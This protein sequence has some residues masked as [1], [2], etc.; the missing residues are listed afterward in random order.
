[1]DE[2]ADFRGDFLEA[3]E[4]EDRAACVEMALHRLEMGHTDVL[5]LYREVLAPALNEWQR[6]EA[7]ADICVW[8]EHVRTSIVRTVV[9][10]A[11]PY[12]VKEAAR[13]DLAKGKGARVAVLCP[14][15]ELHELGARMV[16]DFFTLAGFETTFVGASTPI[17][18]LVAA[19]GHI[20]PRY[21]AISV[22]SPYNLI[23]LRKTIERIRGRV[24]EGTKV[25]VGGRAVAHDPE[26]AKRIG[27]DMVMSTFEEISELP[28][29]G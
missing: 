20:R 22:T 28:G 18:D 27:A 2:L 12:V 10:A 26:L 17:D 6:D 4:R 1:V 19:L 23:A 25:I 15:D 16:A 13:R 9:E 11:Y 3:L 24:P 7:D 14:P 8:R 29:G 5:S 21:V